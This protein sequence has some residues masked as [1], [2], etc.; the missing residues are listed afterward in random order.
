[1]TRRTRGGLM[2]AAACAAFL[3]AHG[4]LDITNA[5]DRELFVVMVVGIGIVVW[6]LNRWWGDR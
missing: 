4:P 2:I 5:A 6:L 1:M 3:L